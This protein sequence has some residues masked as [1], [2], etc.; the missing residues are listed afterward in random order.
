[1]CVCVYVC[2]YVYVR[3]Y[4]CMYVCMYMYG[5]V[6]IYILAPIYDGI[7]AIKIHRFVT[8]KLLNNFSNVTGI[9]AKG[10]RQQ[11]VGEGR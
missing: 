4:V 10:R 6:C 3:M 9:H 11:G 5:C 7:N 8:I 1:M 2:M